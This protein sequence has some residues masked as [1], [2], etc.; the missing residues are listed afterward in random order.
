MISKLPS[1]VWSGAW[2]LAFIAGMVNAVAILG[3]EHQAVSH[4]TGN[5][6]MLAISVARRDV[7]GIRHFIM[8]IGSFLAGTTLSG[9]IIK[10]STLKLGRRYGVALFIESLLLT[11]AVP[12]LNHHNNM[13][14]Y[15]TACACGLQNA[16]AST[17]SGTVV[18][19]THL[20]GMFTDLGISLGHFLRGIPVDKQRTKLSFLVISGFFSGGIGGCAAHHF[21][22]VSALLIPAAFTASASIAFGIYRMHFMR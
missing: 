13:G 15:A 16:M 8:V 12:F 19:T 20:S 14:L 11:M 6:S 17:Y 9:F 2:T 3:F 7:A 22:G 21:I 4:L 18:R 10:D 1:W 5:T